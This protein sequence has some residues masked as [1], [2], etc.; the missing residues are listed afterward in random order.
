MFSHYAICKISPVCKISP[1][2]E[3]LSFLNP[4]S[5]L[6]QCI[7]TVVDVSGKI[8]G[9]WVCHNNI[10]WWNDAEKFH[11]FRQ[12]KQGASKEEKEII[13]K[14]ANYASAMLS[15]KPRHNIFITIIQKLTKIIEDTNKD[16]TVEKYIYDDTEKQ[17]LI[18]GALLCTWNNH[19][20]RPL[21]AAFPWDKNSLNN[22]KIVE[23]PTIFIQRTWW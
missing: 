22:T 2:S 7:L 14:A 8:K 21:N 20:Q 4:R 1:F 13:K 5:H 6:K 23:G 16:A 18:D 3:D 9:N 15:N 17:T 19:N 11:K 12:W 10:W